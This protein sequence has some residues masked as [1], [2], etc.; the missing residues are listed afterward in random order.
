VSRGSS[1]YHRGF[2]LAEAVLTMF[3]V[4]IVFVTTAQILSNAYKVIRQQR[5]KVA[6][7][8]GAQLGLSRMSGELREATNIVQTG[9][10][11]LEFE[12]V[13][14]SLDR[15]GNPAD[16]AVRLT[17]RYEL[18]NNVLTRRVTPGGVVQSVAEGVYGFTTSQLPSGNVAIT[19]AF[20]D[21]RQVKAYDMQVAVPSQW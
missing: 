12:K 20:Q 3:L 11:L 10:S 16:F 9:N 18:Q 21:Q 8:Q 2:S 1:L 15:Y 4:T 14:A 5:Y 13:D 19:L 17:V 6:A 7:Q